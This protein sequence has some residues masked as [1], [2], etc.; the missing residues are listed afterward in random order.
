MNES[1]IARFERLVTGA[2]LQWHPP[3]I[4]QTPWDDEVS[5]EWWHAG[6]KLT[7]YEVAPRNSVE[8]IRVWGHNVDT[9]MSTENDPSDEVLVASWKWL[10]GI[11]EENEAK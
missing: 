1:F 3:H 11:S 8:L 9:E 5:Y 7:A 2:G 10:I 4:S 6:R